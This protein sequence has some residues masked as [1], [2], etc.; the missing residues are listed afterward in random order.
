VLLHPLTHLLE[1]DAHLYEQVACDAIF[2][3]QNRQE[4]M[5]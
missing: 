4:Q 2:L 3:V 5:L 1:V